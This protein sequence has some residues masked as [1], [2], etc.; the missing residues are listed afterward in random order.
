MD[1]VELIIESVRVEYGGGECPEDLVAL[2][3]LF[4]VEAPD[5]PSRKTDA[6]RDK[7]RLAR[8]LERLLAV[9][10]EGLKSEGG[11]PELKA[12]SLGHD[13]ERNFD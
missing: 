13:V 3:L 8:E 12:W 1:E 6:L 5:L 10:N 9:S 2:R 4:L 7:E 11:I